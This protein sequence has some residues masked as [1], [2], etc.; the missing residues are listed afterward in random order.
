MAKWYASIR[1]DATEASL[2]GIYS[3]DFV[4]GC[5]VEAVISS[6]VVPI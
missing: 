3:S 5:V 1:G 4:R 6:T 2:G